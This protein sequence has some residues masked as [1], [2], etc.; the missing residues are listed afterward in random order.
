VVRNAQAGIPSRGPVVAMPLRGV[1]Q[2][3]AETAVATAPQG[4]HHPDRPDV[5]G[6]G[7]PV[8]LDPRLCGDDGLGACH[9]A[10]SRGSV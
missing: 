3:T 1:P 6:D 4:R 9:S 10:C 7:W 2:D 8:F 5:P